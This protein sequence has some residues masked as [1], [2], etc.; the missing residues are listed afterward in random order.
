M[1]LRQV[2]PL[3]VTMVESQPYQAPLSELV[4][5]VAALDDG[6]LTA[7]LDQ[8]AAQLVVGGISYDSRST[9]PGDLFIC[10]VG[11]GH[12]GHDFAEAAIANGAVA[13]VAERQLPL[14]IPQV[15]VTNARRAMAAVSNTFY[16]VPSHRLSVIGVT[17]TN[18]KT[19]LTHMLA[20]I[21]RA[22]GKKVEVL[23][24]LSG[25]R[26]TPEA[27]E[28]QQRLASFADAGVEV[29]AIEVSSHA[30]AQHRVDGTHFDVAV[31]TNLGR[32]HLDYHEN[33]NDYFKAKARLFEPDMAA[34]A[35][36]NLD[37]PY[38]RLLR[39]AALIPTH[40]YS[41]ADIGEVELAPSSS[42]FK[43]HDEKVLVPLGG[44]FNVSNALGAAT[45]AKLMGVDNAAVVA[46]LANLAAIPGRFETVPLSAPFSVI[47]DFAHTPDSLAGVLEA[48]REL[49]LGHQLH[50][51]FGCGGDRD[52]SKR[53]PMGR[54]AS[55]L[56][57]NVIVTSD[58][59]RSE[60]P[61]EIMASIVEGTV[62][63]GSVTAE[64]DRR[65]AIALALKRAAPGDVI[66]IAGKGHESTQE[67]NG[68]FFPFRDSTVVEEEYLRLRKAN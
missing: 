34:V 8:E 45:A 9:G 57:D 22:A 67:I 58:N 61:A 18:G 33:M 46:G 11:G 66:L 53:A 13:L 15:V 36:V 44:R 48:T 30:L 41:M 2:L 16:R 63:Q 40:T 54:I 12:D 56:A 27:P 43:W 25:P 23:G 35:V 6:I 14:P 42:S 37:D 29:A 55:E 47:V 7:G 5:A 21:F 50:V 52:K 19:T 1:K 20:A 17:G 26:T 4:D 65:R 32:D 68:E 31:F 51:V 10:V 24:T 49:A 3:V 59:P 39:D 28:L 38:G 64:V 60:N 62:N